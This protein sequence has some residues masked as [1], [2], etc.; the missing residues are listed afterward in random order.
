VNVFPLVQGKTQ[1]SEK[2]VVVRGHD[3]QARESTLFE[4]VGKAPKGRT[5]F[6]LVQGK[7]QGSENFW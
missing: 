1:G 7:R 6:S 2:F 3:W 4:V 5:R